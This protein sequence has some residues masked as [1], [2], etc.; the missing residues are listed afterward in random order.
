MNRAGRWRVRM[1]EGRV[2]LRHA[3]AEEIGSTGT[4]VSMSTETNCLRDH[5]KTK[6]PNT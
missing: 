4:V 6:P 2:I 3:G 5:L 1:R